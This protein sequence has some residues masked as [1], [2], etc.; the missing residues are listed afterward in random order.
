MQFAEVDQP[1]IRHLRGA[2]VYPAERPQ[3]LEL[4]D[5]RILGFGPR[6]VRIQG[7]DSAIGVLVEPAVQGFDHRPRSVRQAI[8]D[9]FHQEGGLAPDLGVRAVRG[10]LEGGQGRFAQLFERLARCRSLNDLLPSCRTRASGEPES[11]AAASALPQAASI[12]ATGKNEFMSQV[13]GRS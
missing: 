7:E 5:I 13:L 11:R 6:E 9:G 4:R 8:F 3:P 10:L 1:G 2:E 12:R